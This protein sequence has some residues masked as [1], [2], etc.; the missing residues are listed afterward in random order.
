MIETGDIWLEEALCAGREMSGYRENLAAL[1]ELR[2]YVVDLPTW[3]EQ[4]NPQFGGRRPREL[5]QS[6]EAK[7]LVETVKSM[8]RQSPA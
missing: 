5:L 7:R 6:G 4:H 1:S 2:L 8:A 3:L